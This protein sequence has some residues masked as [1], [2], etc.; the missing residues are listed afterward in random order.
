MLSAESFSPI[1]P[2]FRLC[3]IGMSYQHGLPWVFHLS[4]PMDIEDL[5]VKMIGVLLLGIGLSVLGEVVCWLP[6]VTPFV[7][8]VLSVSRGRVLLV[9][10]VGVLRM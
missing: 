10:E 4:L 8:M 9:F 3:G 5:G 7:S 2:S 6:L 1:H